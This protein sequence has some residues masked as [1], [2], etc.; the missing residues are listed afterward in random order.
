MTQPQSISAPIGG[1]YLQSALFCDAVIRGDDGV[2]T[3]IRVIDRVNHRVATPNAS[4]DMVPFEYDLTA[5]IMLK[6]GEV[7]GSHRLALEIINP[8]G[9]KKEA[10]SQDI[11]MEG[12]E[13][14]GVNVVLKMRILFAYSGLHW[15]NV[16]FDDTLLTKMP[17]RIVYL[18]G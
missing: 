12:E 9:E 17:L 10:L 1:P 5:V 13:D 18:R 2:L 6:A 8:A 7:R 4:A 16:V 11:Y 3:I 15:F 14:R